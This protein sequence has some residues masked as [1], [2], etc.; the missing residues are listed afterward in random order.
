MDRDEL[1]PEADALEQE[2]PAVEP[3]VDPEAPADAESGIPSSPVEA[4]I[5]DL[6]DQNLDVGDD[7]EP[8]HPTE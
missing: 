4:D 2:R 3:V 8:T 7:D 6:L 1:I 5:A